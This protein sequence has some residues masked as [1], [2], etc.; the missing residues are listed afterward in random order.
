M[1]PQM[2]T[3]YHY[4]EEEMNQLSDSQFVKIQESLQSKQKKM[5]QVQEDEIKTASLEKL[6]EKFAKT[7]RKKEY[8]MWDVITGLF[9]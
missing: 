6:K 2:L 3:I 5:I 4:N 8:S 7:S 1:A 9:K